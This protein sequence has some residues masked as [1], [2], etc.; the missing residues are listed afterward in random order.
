[1]LDIKNIDQINE[2][3]VHHLE[4]N[5]AVIVHQPAGASLPGPFC[6]FQQVSRY[7]LYREGTVSLQP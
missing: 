5:R 3:I 6:K 7:I 2:T 4:P 1:M